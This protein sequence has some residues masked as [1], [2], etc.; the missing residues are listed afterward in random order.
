[1]CNDSTRQPNFWRRNSKSSDQDHFDQN[2]YENLFESETSSD[3]EL[4][5]GE[6]QNQQVKYHMWQVEKV[7]LAVCK[8]C[9]ME[10]LVKNQFCGTN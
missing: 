10:I 6:S 9:G 7:L 3:N 2:N 8:V 5:N 1:M 4:T